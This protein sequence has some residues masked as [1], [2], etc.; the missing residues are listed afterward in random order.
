MLSYFL[1]CRVRIKHIVQSIVFSVMGSIRFREIE[2]LYG[3]IYLEP[4][5]F[6]TDT[7]RSHLIFQ[8][9]VRNHRRPIGM[10]SLATF[11][12]KVINLIPRE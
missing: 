2:I 9:P 5:I 1:N 11:E 7:S 10:K 4:W 3:E 12:T 6:L 8:L